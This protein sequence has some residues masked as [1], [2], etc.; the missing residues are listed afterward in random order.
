MNQIADFHWTD[1]EKMTLSSTQ[2]EICEMKKS[3]KTNVEIITKFS[4]HSVANIY[5]SVKSTMSGN[6]WE[7]GKDLGGRPSYLSDVDT[8]LFENH[9]SRSCFDLQCLN[10]KE[11]M[12]IILEL[13]QQRYERA[14]LI[15]DL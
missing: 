1:V 7:P 10:T 8:I 14:K 9:I 13:K 5:T 3:R 11:A 6:I 2:I 12:Q 15:A 4:L